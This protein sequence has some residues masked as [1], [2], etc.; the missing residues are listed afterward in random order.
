MMMDSNYV[1]NVLSKDDIIKLCC[2][3]QGFDDYYFDNNGN[4]IFSTILDHHDSSGSFKEYYY[5]ETKTFYCYTR[6]ASYDV[7]EMVRRAKGLDTFKEA[8]DFV[9]N[10]FN[11]KKVGF[12]EE[13]ELELTSD[14]DIF[15]KVKDFSAIPQKETIEARLVQENL[16]E[17]FYP[18]AAP[19]EW[20][21]EGISAGVMRYY[22]I[23]V[24]SALHHIIIP[25]RDKNG[26]LVGIRRRSY[27][28]FE[29]AD[30]KKYMPVFIQG[31]MYNHPLG[32]YLFGLHEAK[33]NI[34][35]TKKVCVFES[36]KSVLQISSYYSIENNFAV[37]T[38][39]SSLSQTQINLLLEL[40]VEEVVLA[41]DRD[42]KG[43]RGDEDVL[44]YEQKLL[45]VITPLLPYVNVSVIM[46]YDHL[47]P[48]EK[49]S[50]SDAGK[51]IFEKL[52]HQRIKL[53]TYTV[54]EKKRTKK[55]G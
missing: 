33:E 23:R 34:K 41:Y 28:P 18:L 38:C 51:E 7:F 2:S 5:V 13:K 44:Q 36:E 1:K 42:F 45:K 32:Q 40:G 14:W 48:Q 46:D 19:T 54:K 4:P 6:A 25:H 30:G 52:Y 39:G 16:V 47:L 12:E 55:H 10:F 43:H 17:Y 8:F 15:Q 49:M 20:L 22:G 31:K 37:A 29:V 24:D 27:D 9:V 50:P 35:K 3:L 26:N 21:R 11:L 53:K